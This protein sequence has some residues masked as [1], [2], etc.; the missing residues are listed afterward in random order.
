MRHCRILH[1]R[2]DMKELTIFKDQPSLGEG[3]D[4]FY[5]KVTGNRN[6][7]LHWFKRNPAQGSLKKAA[8]YESANRKRPQIL[9]AL[10]TRIYRVEKQEALTALLK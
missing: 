3:E 8:L 2:L 6:T 4:E 9:D 1:E 10:L 7:L 5:K